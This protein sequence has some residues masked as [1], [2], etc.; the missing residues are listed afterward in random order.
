LCEDGYPRKPL[1]SREVEFG[2]KALISDIH[3]NLEALR[4]VM[5]DAA[6]LGVS[7]VVCLGDVVG[8]GA[9]A[10][11]CLDVVMD[12]AAATLMGNH[13]FAL[14]HG[15]I[16]FNPIAADVIR[17]IRER[18]IPSK[19][20]EPDPT[21]YFPCVLRCEEPRCMV[22][23][24]SADSR[25]SFV[26]ALPERKE[27]GEILYVHASP[28]DPVFEYVFPDRF[29]S[30]WNPSRIEELLAS[31]ERVCFCGHTHLPCVI[32]DEPACLYPREIGYRFR[33]DSTRKCIVNIGSVGQPRDGDVRASY[34]VFD[35]EGGVVE[36]RRVEYDIEKA[37]RKIEKMC[38]EGNWCGARLRMGR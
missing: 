2:V 9:D 14:I 7:E 24:H 20:H 18:M 38:G 23:V 15:P 35:E 17:L 25:W 16:G 33:L 6:S 31:I 30:G 28:L 4:A 8:Y 19:E 36:W 37:V 26:E 29:R 32:T 34:V 10:E 5:E 11:R 3:G 22:S 12:R 21:G 27:E 1:S 13:D